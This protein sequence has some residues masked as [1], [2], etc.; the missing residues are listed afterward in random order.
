M[1]EGRNSTAIKVFLKTM[2]YTVAVI[3]LL[4]TGY[5]SAEFFFGG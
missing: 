1:K 3:L 2:L 5:F 4:I